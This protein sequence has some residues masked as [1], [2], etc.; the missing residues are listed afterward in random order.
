MTVVE[1]IDR[2]RGAWNLELIEELFNERYRNTIVSPSLSNRKVV[3]EQIRYYS[4]DVNFTV[5]SAYMP[6]S[7]LN[8]DILSWRGPNCGEP[9]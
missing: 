4:R 1:L 3:D 8:I 9:R 2:D 5:K 7:S 6:V